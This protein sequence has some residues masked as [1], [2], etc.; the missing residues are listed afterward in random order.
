MAASGTIS[1]VSR[2]APQPSR[3]A[4]GQRHNFLIGVT[5]F[6]TLVDLFA[7]QAILPSLVEA[8]GVAPSDM[9]VAV[10]ASTIGMAVAGLAVSLFGRRIDQR[11]GI[12]LALGLLSVPTLLLSLMPSLPVFA[13]LRIAQGLCM[14]TAFTLTLAYLGAR[15]GPKEAAGA[16]AA[17]ITGNVASNLFGRLLAATLADHL[18]LAPTFVVFAMM[19]LVGVIVV[20]RV[21]DRVERTEVAP[22][23]RAIADGAWRDHLR[24]A[25]LRAG[26]A[27]GFLILFAF[28][29]TFSY[30]NFVL[31]ADPIAVDPMALGLVYLVFLPSIVSTPL[32]GRLIARIGVRNALWVGFATAGVGLPG[33]VS[34]NLHAILAGLAFFGVGTFLAQAAVTGYVSRRAAGDGGAASGLYLASYFAGG[35]AG[36]AVLGRVFDGLG[37]QA[38]VAGIAIAILGAACLAGRLRE[39]GLVAMIAPRSPIAA[40]SLPPRT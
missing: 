26:F 35:L 37:W 28:I 24:Q 29:G 30:V 40:P 19:N 4:P 6:L 5:A 2:F 31:V 8:Y 39:P 33:F 36:S 11:S 27:I 32:A 17:Y 25:D 38:C 14:A 18:G 13:A 34:G 16:F 7:L 20:A 22:G 10:N 15:S 9:G 23:P 21:I 1:P 3:R 12:M